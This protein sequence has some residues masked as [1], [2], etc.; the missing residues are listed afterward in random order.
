MTDKPKLMEHDGMVCRSCGNEER[1][2]EGYP[3]ADCGT[4]ICLLFARLAAR[5]APEGADQADEGSA[6]GAGIAFRGALLV[7]AGA[8]HHPVV[9]HQFRFV[10]HNPPQTSSPYTL[11]LLIS[12]AREM[13][14]SR[15]ARV[16][17]QASNLRVFSICTRS[18]SA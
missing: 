9:L 14:S 8:A 6:V 15:T 10:G 17:F 3:C 12:V 18:T 16:R 7:A 2:S 5:D 1:A 4:F 11:I 13:P